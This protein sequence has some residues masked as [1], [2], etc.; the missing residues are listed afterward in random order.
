MKVCSNSKIDDLYK[1]NNCRN[2][3]PMWELINIKKEFKINF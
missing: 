1:I 2:L 3:Q